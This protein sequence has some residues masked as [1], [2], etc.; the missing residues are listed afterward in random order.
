MCKKCLNQK[1]IELKKMP[2]N[3]WEASGSA[4]ESKQHLAMLILLAVIITAN[5]FM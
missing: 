2:A 4:I 5:L 1:K 3:Q